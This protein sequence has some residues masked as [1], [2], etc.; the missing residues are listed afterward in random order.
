MKYLLDT[1]TLLSWFTRPEAL[2]PTLLNLLEDRANEL[3]LSV[4]VPWELAAKTNAGMLD[5]HKILDELESGRLKLELQILNA[6]LSHVVRAGMLQFHHRDP[7]QR[8]LAAQSLEL[9]IPILSR[10]PV[11]DLYGVKR[12]W[13]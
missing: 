3:L 13:D 11:F 12:I 6:E 8:L 2:P 1:Q 4:A 7:F 5:A 10:N 9:R